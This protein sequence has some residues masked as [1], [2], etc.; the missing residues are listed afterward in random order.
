MPKLIL[1]KLQCLIKWVFTEE[2]Q[3]GMGRYL[4]MRW[5]M[6]LQKEWV[7][8]CVLL[9]LVLVNTG[10][11]LTW[12]KDLSLSFGVIASHGHPGKEI[13]VKKCPAQKQSERICMSIHELNI[14]SILINLSLLWH[15]YRQ[16]PVSKEK[17]HFDGQFPKCAVGWFLCSSLWEAYEVVC[18]LVA[19]KLSKISLPPLLLCFTWFLHLLDSTSH[20]QSRSFFIC[21]LICRSPLDMPS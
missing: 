14:G 6:K 19:R 12:F 5:Q 10:S 20:I 17:R 18:L 11:H 2:G 16:R 7:N 1:P 8:D 3:E 15:V 9:F 21:C 4:E 13:V